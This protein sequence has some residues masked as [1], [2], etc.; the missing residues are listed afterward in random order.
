MREQ[1]GGRRRLRGSSRNFSMPELM[2]VY[3]AERKLKGRSTITMIGQKADSHAV[4]EKPRAAQSERYDLEKFGFHLHAK[5]PCQGRVWTH[6]D[7][8]GDVVP[9]GLSKHK[10]RQWRPARSLVP[11]RY[12]HI[13]SASQPAKVLGCEYFLFFNSFSQCKVP[14]VR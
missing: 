9:L 14:I 3:P 8:N 13:Q 10:K 5:E 4:V 1:E 11:S 12:E 6:G 7:I 2:W